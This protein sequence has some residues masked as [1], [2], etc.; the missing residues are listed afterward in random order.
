MDPI[1]NPPISHQPPSPP[2]PVIKKHTTNWPPHTPP[3]L[4]DVIKAF[5]NQVF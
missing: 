5:F 2:T 1:S 4:L 3:T